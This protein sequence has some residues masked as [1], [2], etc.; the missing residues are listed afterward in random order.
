MITH[1][2][3]VLAARCGWAHGNPLIYLRILY[4]LSIGYFA[5]V[6]IYI[7]KRVLEYGFLMIDKI[8]RDAVVFP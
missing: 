5:S 2:V 1:R 4:I 8:S 7:G 6:W 3:P